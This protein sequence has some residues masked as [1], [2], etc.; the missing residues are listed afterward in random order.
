MNEARDLNSQL[1]DP[2]QRQDRGA[3]SDSNPTCSAPARPTLYPPRRCSISRLFFLFVFPL[4]QRSVNSER[5]EQDDLFGIPSEDEP[6]RTY[7]QLSAGWRAS[8]SASPGRRKGRRLLRVLAKI[9][10][11]DLWVCW[12]GQ[13]VLLVLGFSYPL[14]LN[15]LLKFV[16]DSTVPVWQGMVYALVLY[17]SGILEGLVEGH[18][19]MGFW[20][21][22]YRIQSSLVAMI[23]RKTLVLRQD[24]LLAFS[25]GKLSNMITTDVDKAAEALRVA[26]IAVTAPLKLIISLFSL[27]KLVGVSIFIGMAWG[28]LITL[29]APVLMRFM[30][31]LDTRQQ[32]KTDERVQ[33]VTELV[34]SV[35]VVKCYAWEEAAAAKIEEARKKELKA[36]WHLYC[37]FSCFEALWRGMI[38]MSTAIM[39]TAYSMLNP[40]TPLTAAQAFTAYSLLGLVE[41]PLFMVPYVANAV[42][43]ALVSSNRIESLFVLPEVQVPATKCIGSFRSNG[44]ALTDVLDEGP[45]LLQDV[46]ISFNGEDYAWPLTRQTRAERG[47]DDEEEATDEI[48]ARLQSAEDEGQPDGDR[49]QQFQLAGIDFKVPHHAFVAVVGATGSGK[50]SLLQAILGEMPP[51]SSSVEQTAPVRREKPIAFTPQ[52]AWIFNATVRQ[53]IIFGETYDEKHYRECL[54]SCGLERDLELLADGDQTKVGEKGIALSGGQKARVCLARAAYRQRGSNLVLLDDPYSALDA[55][56]AKLVHDKLVLGMLRK[57]TRVIATNRLEFIRT[58]DMVV[59]LDEGKVDA[60]GTFKDVFECSSVL[61]NLMCAQGLADEDEA[62]AGSKSKPVAL[63]RHISAETSHSAED[64]ADK[65]KDDGT[66]GLGDAG[67]EEERVSGTVKKEVF[68]YYIQKMGGWRAITF[69]AFSFAVAEFASMCLPILLANWTANE[70]SPREMMHFAWT[71]AG[72]SIAVVF[73]MTFRDIAGNVLGFRAAGNLHKAML[74]SVLRAPMT[75][76]QDTPQGRIINRFSKDTREIDKQ[77]I[78]TVSYTLVPA[79]GLLGNLIMI[80]YSAPMSL[81][82]FL[83]SVWLYYKCFVFYN[84]TALDLKR[85]EKTT[86][87]PVYDHFSNICRENGCAVVRA[88]A[89]VEQQCQR[90]S[91]LL[92]MEM[93]PNYSTMFAEKWFAVCMMML[94][95]V[96]MLCVSLYVV[97]GRDSL[98]S[99]ATAALALTFGGLTAESMQF[100]VNQLAEFGVAFNCVERV[101]EYSVDLP[102]EA[103]LVAGHRPPQGWPHEG[104]LEIIDLKLRYKP[105]LPLVLHGI[106]FKTWAGERVGVVGRTGAGKSSLLLALLRI[107]EP[108][109]GSKIILDGENLLAMGLRDVRTAIAMIPQ[110]AVLFEGTLRRNVDPYE[111]RTDDEVWAALEGSQFAAQVRADAERKRA[112]TAQAVERTSAPEGGQASASDGLE[113]PLASNEVTPV[114]APAEFS[115]EEALKMDI[116]EGG[117]NLSIGQRQMVSIARAV[118]RKAKIVVLDEATAAIDAAN[119]AAIQSAIRTCFRGATT[120]TIAHRLQTILD[121]DRVLVLDAGHIAELAPPEELQAREGSIFRSMVEEAQQQGEA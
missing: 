33:K 8:L 14:F 15:L 43:E 35:Q 102:A 95:S 2:D 64:E 107:A 48:F 73:F 9:H 45:G 81:V 109:E 56:V 12:L 22:G 52:Q 100:L 75:F 108:E 23:F 119:D 121:S 7:E 118:L 4:M 40:E 24:V 60:S 25:T 72:I 83:P 114:E 44:P 80:G 65:E 71:Y 82:A 88:H 28:L 1:L 76:F 26:H 103:A 30:F 97:L 31:I 54:A 116:K 74:E 84:K 55:H 42:V 91:K 99:P 79:I 11:R 67:D 20:R 34:T 68:M 61:R 17:L 32:E 62:N 77:I 106:S 36:I 92:S 21:V 49:P 86:S 85:I 37:L 90:N 111:E 87:S 89:Q 41:Q 6:Q 113:V 69:L 96:L 51:R 19:S 101:M 27:Y 93:R 63:T 16:N 5:L 50:T 120:L 104:V 70:R 117:Q 39:F 57:K 94:S 3:P 78:W 59:V 110:E 13:L 18:A 47:E 29:T 98:V 53:N 105:E 46:A 115:M 66:N 112:N 10:L 38:P 58:A